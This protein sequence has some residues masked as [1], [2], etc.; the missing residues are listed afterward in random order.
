M[1]EVVVSMPGGPY[2][3]YFYI[4]IP[5]SVA[6]TSS[7]SAL[8]HQGNG[9]ADGDSRNDTAAPSVQY[10]RFVHVKEEESSRFPMQFGVEVR[11]K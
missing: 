4:E 5:V 1:D 11:L 8:V 7:S 9:V 3:E 6:S 2:Q 10:R